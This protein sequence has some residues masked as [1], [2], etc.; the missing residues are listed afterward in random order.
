MTQYRRRSLLGATLASVVGAALTRPAEACTRVLFRGADDTV[1]TGRSMDWAEDMASELWA[2]PSGMVR[3]GAG[4][5]G[6]P[7]WTARYGSVIAAGYNVGTA[8]GMNERGL[9]ANMLYL[10]ESEY[11]VATPGRPPLSISTW[12]QYALDNFATVAEAVTALAPEPFQVIAPMLPNGQRASLHLSLSDAGGDSAIF[13]YIGGKLVIHHGREFTVMTNS[14]SFDQQIAIQR[15]WDQIGGLNFLPGTVRAADR[16]AR[17]KFF[18]NAVPK[19]V[20]RAYIGAVPGRS[21]G[22]Q[23]LAQVLSVVRGVGVPLGISVEGQPNLASTIWRTVADQKN[24]IYFFDS[25]MKPN[26]FWVELSK[27]NL[28]AGAP[29]MKLPMV[30]DEVYA[31]EVSARFVPAPPFTFLPAG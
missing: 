19:Q 17:A 1:I 5:A 7:R 20:D 4:G 18:L 28:R 29:A 30:G 12:A 15:Y 10:A 3:D 31:G 6:T 24:L 9:V 16:F 26:T 21:F 25:A 27:L 11:G 8:D 13:E 23:A 22:N 2:F 14:P